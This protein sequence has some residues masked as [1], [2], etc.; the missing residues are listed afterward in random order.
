M[1]EELKSAL[2]ALKTE[3]KGANATEAKSLIESLESKMADVIAGE[4]KAGN[5]T[6]K[7]EFEAEIK[8]V[9]DHADAL[10][11]K[12]QESK[13]VETSSKDEIKSI[14]N[15]NFDRISQVRK[16]NAVEVKA[17]MTLGTSL[18]GD[19]PRDYNF[20][21][22]MDPSQKINVSDLIGMVSISGGTYTFP[23]ETGSN[24][25]FAY[26]VEGSSKAQIDYT[27]EMVDV[28]TDFLAGYSRYSRKMKNN[29]PFLESFLPKALR[30]DYAKAENADFYTKISGA[31]TASTVVTGNK[32]ERLISDI[33]ALENTNFDVNGVVVNVSDWW[34]IQ[35][36]EASTGAGYGLPGVV[37]YD[38][39]VLRINGL[40][41]YKATWIPADKYLVGDWSRVN[42]VVTEGLSLEFSDVEG[43]NFVANNITARLEAQVNVAVEQPDAVIFGDFTAI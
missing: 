23:R 9:Q 10:D 17:D 3:I 37:T 7:S 14:L 19:Q 35:V 16:G 38:G 13:K 40:P 21:T 33:A 29:L 12:L 30:R 26:Q 1:N 6:I 32:I 43:T 20:N 41:I 15:E 2:E 25:G 42:K 8:K 18:T 24:G 39:G 4:V 28:N 22:V 27:L 11:M 36:T 5:E 31:A 34:D